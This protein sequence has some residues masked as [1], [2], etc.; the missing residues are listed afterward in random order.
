MVQENSYGK[1]SSDAAVRRRKEVNT[2]DIDFA[3][4][5]YI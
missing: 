4:H 1:R 5:K 2:N 3:M